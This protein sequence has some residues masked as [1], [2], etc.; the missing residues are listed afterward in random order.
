MKID[1]QHPTAIL[2]FLVQLMRD[3]DIERIDIA[4]EDDHIRGDLHLGEGH[5]AAIEADTL[6]AGSMYVSLEGKVK[7][8]AYLTRSGFGPNVQVSFHS[9]RDATDEEKIADEERTATA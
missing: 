3:N 9:H 7:P 4:V 8:H 2:D 5:C 1:P 6:M